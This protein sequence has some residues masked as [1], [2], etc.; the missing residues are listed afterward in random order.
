MEGLKE[1][2]DGSIYSPI[3]IDI[4]RALSKKSM[5]RTQLVKEMN[6]PRTTLYDN[7]MGLIA[8]NVVSKYSK[9]LNRRGRPLVFFRLLVDVS[10][11]IN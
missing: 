5:T 10:N 3:Q 4:V 8:H 7:L 6:K 9:P 1:F 2:S 11:I